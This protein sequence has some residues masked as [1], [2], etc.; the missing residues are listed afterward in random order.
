VLVGAGTASAIWALTQNKG[1]TH[2]TQVG[3]PVTTIAAGGAPAAPSPAPAS[4]PPTANLDIRD[5]DDITFSPGQGLLNGEVIHMV[6]TGFTPGLQYGSMECKAGSYDDDDCDVSG[7]QTETADPSG[8]LTFD[9]TA[10]KGPFGGHNV[11]CKTAE[12]CQI[13]IAPIE[14]NN[15]SQGVTISLGFR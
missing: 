15:Y 7:F 3:A 4:G 6:A 8:T 2:S 9:Y 12:T 5:G 1:S 14:G 11:V 13:A 10:L